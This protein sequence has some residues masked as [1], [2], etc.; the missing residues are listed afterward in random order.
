MNKK[1]KLEL[2]LDRLDNA[3]KDLYH[4]ASPNCWSINDET[5]NFFDYVC[6]EGSRAIEYIEDGLGGV[7]ERQIKLGFTHN[8]RYFWLVSRIT[9]YGKLYQW[10]R[11][12]RTVA[13]NQLVSQRGGSSFRIK[14]AYDLYMD[15]TKTEITD[16]IQVLEAFNHYVRDWNS[17]ETMQKLYRDYLEYQLE[18]A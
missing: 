6:E 4:N 14:S 2:M 8:E 10:G 17:E 9:E 1:D 13:P 18:A 7:Y 11:G 16:M 15:M 5:G 3:L 12:G